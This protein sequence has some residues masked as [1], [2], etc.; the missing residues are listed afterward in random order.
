[1]AAEGVTGP[2]QLL[3]VAFAGNEFDGS[4]MRE[5]ESLAERDIVRLVDMLFVRKTTEGDLEAVQASGLS[6]DEAEEFGAIAGALI[7]V[8]AGGAAGA[9]AGAEAGAAAAADGHLIDDDEVW[10]VADAIPD[11]TAAA[12][13]LL[14]HRWATGLRDAAQAANGAML[15]EEWIHPLDLVAIGAMSEEQAGG[16]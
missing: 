13:V 7:G 12:I 2:V 16:S 14:E 5:L 3:V 4:M 11:G 6:T 8:G 15:A 10:Y 1:M 9:E